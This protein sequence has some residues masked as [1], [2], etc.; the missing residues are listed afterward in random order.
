M[1]L[2][3]IKNFESYHGFVDRLNCQRVNKRFKIVDEN[4]DKHSIKPLAN[5]VFHLI[6]DQKILLKPRVSQEIGGTLRIESGLT[7]EVIDNVRQNLDV[8]LEDTTRLK[9]LNRELKANTPK[10]SKF[11]ALLRRIFKGKPLTDARMDKQLGRAY[12]KSIQRE[13]N[14]V[15]KYNHLD[16]ASRAVLIEKLKELN[17]NIQNAIRSGNTSEFYP[18]PGESAEQ[19]SVSS[20][21]EVPIAPT[22]PRSR[23]H[24]VQPRLVPNPREEEPIQEERQGVDVEAI[25]RARAGLQRPAPVERREPEDHPGDKHAPL[26][27]ALQN[28][29]PLARLRKV[30]DEEKVRN[31]RKSAEGNIQGALG[32]A[33]DNIR[34]KIKESSEGS[35]SS[36]VKEE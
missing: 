22:P 7:R 30:P 5:K 19:P 14:K 1:K 25:Q 20:F 11:K 23:S 15:K 18:T 29:E 12:E 9:E 2:S 3:N 36:T 21:R 13:I 35:S 28:P 8:V 24:R 16:R 27:R 4:S 33:I 32:N 17:F 26:M 10:L 6:R 31:P 34:D